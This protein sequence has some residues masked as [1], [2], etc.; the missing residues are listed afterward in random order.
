MGRVVESITRPPEPWVAP[1]YTLV[2]EH[3]PDAAPEFC[4]SLTLTL[5]AAKFTG[6]PDL[7]LLNGIMAIFT[8]GLPEI[9]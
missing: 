6:I 2:R 1:A 8:V 9:E 4:E 3:F 5:M 7:Q